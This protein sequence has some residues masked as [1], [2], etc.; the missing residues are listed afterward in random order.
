MQIGLIDIEPNIFNTAYM[1]IAH[2]HKQ[3]GDTVEWVAPLEYNRFDKLYCSSLFDYT[4][5][6][7][8]PSN[9]ICGGTGYDLTTELPFDCD[10]DYSIYPKCNTSYVWFSRGCARNCPWCVVPEKEG[11]YH[12]VRRK[13]LNPKGRYLTIMDNDFFANENWEDIISWI[14]SSPVDIQG[15][16]VRKMTMLKAE[17]L[18]GLKRWDRKQFKIAWDNPKGEAAI[19]NGIIMLTE[20]MPVGAIMCY[21]LIGHSSTPEEDLHRIATLKSMGIDPYVMAFDRKDRYQKKFQRWVNGHAYR[22]VKWEDFK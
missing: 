15:I 19:R 22:N 13:E 14:G 21:V 11:K 2:H 20:Y 9:A 1:Q 10:Y 3:L 12:T 18:G 6:S 8:V 17:A 7:Q 5:K 4:D 16:D